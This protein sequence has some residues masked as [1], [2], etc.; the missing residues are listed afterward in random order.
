MAMSRAGRRRLILAVVLA[1]GV[2]AAGGGYA[3][4]QAQMRSNMARWLEEGTA[5]HDRGDYEATVANLNEFV[6]RDKTNVEALLDFADARRRIPVEAGSILHFAQAQNIT[7]AAL[8]LEPESLRGRRMLLE[9]YA[10]FEDRRTE[11]LDAAA[12]VLELA[13]NDLAAHAARI[14]VFNALGRR[15]DALAATRAMAEAIPDDLSVQL[16]AFGLMVSLDADTASLEAF[17][18]DRAQRFGGRL[19]LE[20]MRLQYQ[21]SRLIAMSPVSPEYPDQLVQYVDT[22]VPAAELP[23]ENEEEARRLLEHL[24]VVARMNPEFNALAESTLA[25]YMQDPA[26]ADEM[27]ALAAEQAWSQGSAGEAS[28]LL[29]NATASVD[30]AS[31][32]TLGWLA[33]TGGEGSA[34]ALA[35]LTERTTPEARGWVLLTEA[36]RLLDEGDPTAALGALNGL[37]SIESDAI[38]VGLHLRGQALR[39][40]GETA[41]AA[42]VWQ[43][44]LSEDPSWA[45]TSAALAEA[46]LELGRFLDAR[47]AMLGSNRARMVA[48]MLWLDIELAIDESGLRSTTST[49][50]DSYQVASD[51]TELIPGDPSLMA[52]QARAALATGRPNQARSIVDELLKADLS[53]TAGEAVPLVTALNRVDAAR[54]KALR[55]ALGRTATDPATVY[56]LAI[57][58]LN[59]GMPAEGRS[60]LVQGLAAAADEDRMTWEILTGTFDDRTQAEGAAAAL[61]ELSARYPDNAMVQRQVLESFSVWREPEGLGAVIERLRGITGESGYQWRLFDLKRQ[62]AILDPDDANAVERAAEIQI[63]I[64]QV[65]REDPK[66]VDALTI[67]SEAAEIAGDMSRAAEFMVRASEAAPRDRGLKLKLPDLLARA[68]RLTEASTRAAA[69][70]ELSI[71]EPALLRQRADVLARFGH[72]DL[73]RADWEKLARQGD[74]GAAVQFASTLAATGQLERADAIVEEILASEGVSDLA[75]SFAATYLAN[76]G[77]VDRGLALLRSLPEEGEAGR[78]GNRIGRYLAATTNDEEAARRN[79]AIAEEE[80]DAELWAAAAQGYLRLVM[81][82]EAREV[83]ERGLAKHPQ[84]D[85]L[86]SIQQVFDAVDGQDR[87]AR[88]ALF[89]SSLSLAPSPEVSAVVAAIARRLDGEIDDGE[90]ITTLKDISRESPRSLA[91]WQGLALAQLTAERFDGATTTLRDAMD[92]L[93]NDVA[94]AKFATDRLSEIGRLEDAL[95]AARQWAVR[96]G[97]PSLEADQTIAALLYSLGRHREALAAIEPWRDR[98]VSN[99]AN[100]LGDVVLLATILASTGDAAGAIAVYTPVVSSSRMA[101]MQGIELTRSI[102]DTGAASRWLAGLEGA[103]VDTDEPEATVRYGLA[104][105]DVVVRSADAEIARQALA[106]M[107]RLVELESGN[108]AEIRFV[109]AISHERLGQMDEAISTYREVLAQSPDNVAARNNLAYALLGSGGDAAE[110]LVLATEAVEMSRS[111]GAPPEGQRS[112]LDTRAHALMA[113]GRAKDAVAVYL[114]GLAAGPEWPRGLIGLAEAQAE[115][116]DPDG[117]RATLDRLEIDSLPEDLAERARTLAASLGG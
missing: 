25:R 31:D 61:Y 92:A 84:S 72:S 2:A 22:L 34:E 46:F 28:Q 29:S 104:W 15:E 27:V 107:G 110:A 41:Q 5:A 26:L 99:R 112:F 95:F 116:G 103:I 12:K 79:V 113:L 96:L 65:I 20:L 117:A 91:V 71:Q 101:L 85:A 66:N 53:E 105:L 51:L 52:L 68:G 4:R 48:P 102:R 38:R 57:A 35:A 70:A 8:A 69:L 13:P 76:R 109:M 90:L 44:L 10:L 115:S 97:G 62:L 75:K 17:L 1:A 3:F 94:I 42:Q 67:A 80:D 55:E 30:T 74:D 45:I 9:L 43:R 37:P 58:D 14:E 73:A 89:S 7:Q 106:V 33:L 81:L 23:P 16:D 98:I 39:E 100:E 64:A 63:R 32:R 50:R 24:R 19:G 56:G 36:S 83:T 93:T 114:E 78:R 108:R 6:S 60:R 40:T 18:E 77:D 11:T 54:A 82:D 47:D 21:R 111:A 59:A 49:G 87:T 86:R 88:L